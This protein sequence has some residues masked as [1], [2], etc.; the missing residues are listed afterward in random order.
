LNA[1]HQA[2]N[3][4]VRHQEVKHGDVLHIKMVRNGGI[5]AR[6]E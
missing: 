6:I 3:Y 4:D 5:E 1:G 2:M